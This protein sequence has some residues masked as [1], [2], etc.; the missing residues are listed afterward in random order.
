MERSI[1]QATSGDGSRDD[2]VESRPAA[3]QLPA[4]AGDD[5]SGIAA[6][7]GDGAKEQGGGFG[8]WLGSRLTPLAAGLTLMLLCMA[9]YV[10]SNPARG[11]LYI[12]F[13]LQAQAW[14]D[15]QTSIPMPQYQDVMPITDVHGDQT[16]RGIIPFPPLPALVLMPF[17]AFWH[18]DTN[19]QLL[20]AIF[21]GVDVGIA[22]WMLG[23]LPI[24]RPIRWLTALFLGLGTVLWYASALG[25]TWFWA[26]VVAVG[27]LLG[28][29]GFALSGDPTAAEPRPLAEDLAAARRPAWPGGWR[30]AAAIVVLGALGALLFVLARAGTDAAAMAAVGVLLA[31][32][33]AVL[34]LAVAGRP[35]VLTPL[36]VVLLFVGGVPAALLLGASSAGALAV[37]DVVAVGAVIGL[38][39]LAQTHPDRIDR[40]TD[41]FREAMDRPESRQIAAGLLFGLACTSRL[42]IVF[43][44]PFLLLVGGGGSWL[45]RGMLAGAG[46]AVPLVALLVYTYASTGEL[47]NPA[48][49][50][51]YTLELGYISAGLPYHPNLSIEDLGYVPQNL[52]IMLFSLPHFLPDVKGVFPVGGDPVCTTTQARG[53][54]SQ[55]CPLALP[56]AQ[57]MSLIL[58]SPAYLLAPFAFMRA[59]LGQFDRVTV[60]AA[61]AV[62]AIAFVNLMHFSQGWVQFGYRFSNDFAPFAIVLVALGASRLGRHWA[63]LL[64]PLVAASIAI[65][66]WGTTWGMMLGW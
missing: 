65:N 32:A 4:E 62:V 38:A 23:Y 39:M 61:I 47:F 18:L 46:A 36:M 20:A 42:T 56:D 25:S 28:A 40:A 57:G 37:V 44:F 11:N 19:Q 50:Y 9:V 17:V 13:V 48:Y 16:G 12:H 60:G 5:P 63:W 66:F 41:A 30:A 21:G 33:A 34:A 8:S 1:T 29:I 15:G 6:T 26:H 45:R 2:R 43:G 49:N 54:F 7:D 53:L 24:R 51:Q 14:M 10:Y 35:G 3:P 58:T 31:I 27:F 55:A 59:R 22:Y 64:V 52:A